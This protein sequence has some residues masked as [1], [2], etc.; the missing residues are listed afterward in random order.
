MIALLEAVIKVLG[1][2]VDELE[3]RVHAGLA[4]IDDWRCPMVVVSVDL[5]HAPVLGVDSGYERAV[6]LARLTDEI[7]NPPSERTAIAQRCYDV[8][9]GRDP[10]A[11]SLD[12]VVDSEGD[13]ILS[14][15]R[16]LDV[17][18]LGAKSYTE[19]IEGRRIAH[20]ALQVE[21]SLER[22]P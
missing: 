9:T 2:E 7:T 20:L 12:A 14:D 5:E 21:V 6:V 11:P 3:G 8:L 16:I 22:M 17:G 18:R 1:D 19:S 4:P 15:W 13:V 10:S